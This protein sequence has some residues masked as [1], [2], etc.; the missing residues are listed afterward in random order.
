[1]LVIV[2]GQSAPQT[3]QS[4]CP[5]G[6]TPA[7]DTI[8]VHHR[9]LLIVN[10]AKRFTATLLRDNLRSPE[11]VTVILK[12]I[13]EQRHLQTKGFLPLVES[14]GQIGTVQAEGKT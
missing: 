13:Q 10:M 7:E 12:C 5:V 6:S 11:A 4:S 8:V 9:N 2:A 3:P 1:M 14:S